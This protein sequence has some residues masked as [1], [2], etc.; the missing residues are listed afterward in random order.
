VTAY[1]LAIHDLKVITDPN[2]LS[3]GIRVAMIEHNVAP[4]ELIEFAKMEQ[5]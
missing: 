4:V 5:L 1:G 3:E 2:P